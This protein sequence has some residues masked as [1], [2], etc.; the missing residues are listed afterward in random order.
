[1]TEIK[2]GSISIVLKRDSALSDVSSLTLGKDLVIKASESCQISNLVATINVTIDNNSKHRR[3]VLI[4][5]PYSS[6]ENC[7][8][9]EGEILTVLLCWDI[10]RININTCKVVAHYH[11]DH[12]GCNFGIFKIDRGYIIY[13]ELEILLLNLNFQKEWSF[14]GQ[15]IFV[16]NS[17]CIPFEIRQ[18]RICLFDIYGEYYEIDFNC[19][20]IRHR[21]ESES[22]TD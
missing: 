8:V 5:N 19:K 21:K 17:E 15:D 7:A 22:L 9:L 20:E 10:V 12:S 18:D 14:S 3:F 2:T 6:D 4:G 1:M 16:S 13:G 11:L